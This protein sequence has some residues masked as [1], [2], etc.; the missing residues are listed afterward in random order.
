[1]KN[2]C[3]F[4]PLTVVFDGASYWLVDGFH[5]RWAAIKSKIDKFKCHVVQGTREDARWLSYGVNQDHGL[6][7][8]NEDKKKAVIAA[9]KH[10]NGAKKSDT[11]IAAH[12]GVNDKTVAK[13]RSELSV[14]S[15][16]PK[17]ET[18]EVTRGGTTYTQDTANIGRA[19][20]PRA[21]ELMPDVEWDDDDQDD[22]EAVT[23]ATPQPVSTAKPEHNGD[24]F[25][26]LRKLFDEMKPAQRTQAL[27]LWTDW[28]A[29][30]S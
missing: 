12:V 18:R 6:P 7:R 26:K 22:E 10:P 21:V 13:Y 17:I 1:M 24:T 11:A 5:R 2:G 16:I 4:P 14:S 15:E 30:D 20:N 9:L 27:T 25:T 19:I 28:L 29:D 23:E 8:T 3:E